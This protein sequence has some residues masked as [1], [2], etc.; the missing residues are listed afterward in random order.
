MAAVIAEGMNAVEGVEAKAFSLEEADTD[1]VKESQCVIV[2]TPSYY[3]DM[4]SDVKVW[5]EKSAGKCGIAGKLGGAFATADYI[6]GGGDVAV[7]SIL[8][9]LM[10][11]G[12]VVYSGGGAHGLPVI[13]MGPIALSKKLDESKDT[14]LE[15]GKRMAGKAQELFA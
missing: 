15:Y 9:H 6:H 4:A 11:C 3:A 1:F 8:K 14:F 10:V 5:L 7:Q 12:M 13:H 2:G